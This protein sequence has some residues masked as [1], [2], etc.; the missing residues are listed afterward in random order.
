M[1]LVG[2]LQMNTLDSLKEKVLRSTMESTCSPVML[3][4]MR[5]AMSH[6]TDGHD[7]W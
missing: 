2:W 3:E 1:Y 7:S 4:R 6:T 5:D